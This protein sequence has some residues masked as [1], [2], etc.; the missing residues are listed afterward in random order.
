MAERDALVRRVA[1][2]FV[3]GPEDRIEKSPDAR[4]RSAIALVFNKFSEL[5]SVRQVFLWFDRQQI[6]LP[7]AV[8]PEGSSEI[9]WRPARYHAVHSILKNPIYAY[10]RSRTVVRWGRRE[11]ADSTRQ[12]HPP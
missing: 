5:R 7:V 8:G 3:K 10:G 11:E 4:I 6:Q 12:A 2:G 1:I 9:L